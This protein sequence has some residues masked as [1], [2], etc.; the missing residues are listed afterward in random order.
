MTSY[1]H[2][3]MAL[4]LLIIALLADYLALACDIDAARRSTPGTPGGWSDAAVDDDSVV[5][6]KDTVAKDAL[7]TKAHHVIESYQQVNS[8]F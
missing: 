4:L 1:H 2:D 7:V 6:L 3:V 5:E 8:D